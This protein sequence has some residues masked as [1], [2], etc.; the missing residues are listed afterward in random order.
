MYEK[1]TQAHIYTPGPVKM[2]SDT[3]RLGGMQTPYFRNAEFSHL[4]LE[5]ESM[6]LKLANAPDGSR[7]VF[8]TASGT[9]AMEAAVINLLSPDRPVGIVNGG[10]FGQRFVDICEVHRVP[11]KEAKVDRDPL[12]DGVALA[13]LKGVE[14]LLINAHE[15]SVGHCYD[16]QATGRWCRGQGALH[17]VDAI[18]LF[19]TDPLDMQADGIDALIISSHKGL[20]L[21]PGLAM[22]LLSPKALARVHQSGSYYL[23]FAM[24]LRD[25]ERGQTPFTPAV[26]IVLQLH[27]RLVQIHAEGA[28]VLWQ[29]TAELASYFRKQVSALPLHFYS[30]HMP[31]AMTALELGSHA[32]LNAVQVVQA[33]DF[34]YGC[35]VAPNGGALR[36]RVFRVSH[37]GAVDCEDMDRLVS[38]L[39]SVLEEK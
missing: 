9:G 6:L 1:L 5:S 7:C 33:L 28:S 16:L 3:L 24:H 29:R 39:T 13:K 20:A 12:T 11:V 27:Q 21:P 31:N 25:G 26:S 36:E 32:R 30:L 23:D 10:S 2:A 8:I 14:A 34:Q 35:V 22:V 4:V 19:V 38:A 17:I 18:S 37:M 15:T